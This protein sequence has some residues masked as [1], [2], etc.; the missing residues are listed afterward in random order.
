LDSCLSASGI[1]AFRLGL[2]PGP[3]AAAGLAA[4]DFGQRDYIEEE[5]DLTP[6]QDAILRDIQIQLCGPGLSGWPQLG[7]DPSGRDRM[8]VDGLAA[9]LQQIAELRTE[10]SDLEATTAELGKQVQRLSNHHWPWP[11]SL[12]EGPATLVGDQ[13][14]RLESLLNELPLVGR[15]PNGTRQVTAP[16][17]VEHTPGQA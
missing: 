6:E 15:G 4:A 3:A 9:A 13:L 7:T 2:H 11:L 12:L 8:L 10:I 5:A 17:P 1:D 16:E 14:S